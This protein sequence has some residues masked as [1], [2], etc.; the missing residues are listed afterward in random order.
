MP[1]YCEVD[2]Y[3]RGPEALRNEFK[4]RVS[5]EVPEFEFD[6]SKGKYVQVRTRRSLLDFNSI[7]PR[8]SIYDEFPSPP[9]EKDREKSLLAL[10]LHGHIDWYGWCNAN[11]GVKWNAGEVR[12]KESKS[13]LKYTFE[14]PWG[15]PTPI[16]DK[17]ASMFPGLEITA[18]YFECGMAFKG[19][20]KYKNGTLVEQTSGNYN[21][22]RGG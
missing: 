6:S 17:L 5:G 1:N 10:Q 21:G 3:V 12:L 8:P 7:T 4:S 2:L 15:P 14:T 13:S 22:R 20:R 11:W 19:F 18:R 9:S 16:L